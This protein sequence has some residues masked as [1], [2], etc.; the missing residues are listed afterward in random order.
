MTCHTQDRAGGQLSL[1][2][3][4]TPWA[5]S[6]IPGNSVTTLWEQSPHT[7]SLPLGPTSQPSHSG[8]MP[9]QPQVHFDRDPAHLCIFPGLAP[10]QLCS[11]QDVS[12]KDGKV[13]AQ[14]AV[15][16][17]T[18]KGEADSQTQKKN[19]ICTQTIKHGGLNTNS[20]AVTSGFKP[21]SSHWPAG[22]IS[23][24]VLSRA[25]TWMFI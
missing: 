18:I 6:P 19:L 25:A 2:S 24:G 3:G 22:C 13:R 4:T 12:R 15:S 5:A 11:M 20:G 9:F 23:F 16:G 7:Q 17:L 14:P 8:K 1:S 10:V 21:S